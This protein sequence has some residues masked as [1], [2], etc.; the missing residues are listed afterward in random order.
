MKSRVLPLNGLLIINI[1]CIF[2]V[3][4]GT[5]FDDEPKFIVNY[6]ALLSLFNMFCFNCKSDSPPV[7]TKG[8]GTLV[9]VQQECRNGPLKPYN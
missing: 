6:S 7:S 2:R 9:A 3:E 1:Y 8:N 4:P 5:T